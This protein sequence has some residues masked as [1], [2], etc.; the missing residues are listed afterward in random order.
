MDSRKERRTGMVIGILGTVICIALIGIVVLLWLG[1]SSDSGDSAVVPP[2]FSTASPEREETEPPQTE[3]TPA[4]LAVTPLKEGVVEGKSAFAFQGQLV[5]FPV[6][7]TVWSAR[8]ADDGS[9][10][11]CYQDAEIPYEVQSVAIDGTNLVMGTS[12][13]VYQADLK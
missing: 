11:D 9:L 8:I 12:D 3:E 4:P 2:S 13:G 5:F 1:R 6:G 7:N 10:Y